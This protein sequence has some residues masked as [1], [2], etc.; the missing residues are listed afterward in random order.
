MNRIRY[1]ITWPVACT[2]PLRLEICVQ[3]DILEADVASIH[4][5]VLAVFE[6]ARTGAFQRDIQRTEPY[7]FQWKKLQAATRSPAYLLEI[8]F[9]DARFC[10]VLLNVLERFSA[11]VQATCKL[12]VS[13]ADLNAFAQK[14]T[15]PK[16]TFN[17]SADFYPPQVFNMW[18]KIDYDDAPTDPAK[19]R[20]LLL[21]FHAD[22]DES[23]IERYIEILDIW[24]KVLELNGYA[25]PVRSVQEAMVIYDGAELYTDRIIEANLPLFEASDEAWNALFNALHTQS[26]ELRELMGVWL[27]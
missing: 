16:P 25:P 7:R 15:F 13:P 18:F 20:R 6:L 1:D 11:E 14:I 27:S 19:Y 22:L 8:S 3:D 17:N 26:T 21:V 9:V 23:M 12:I 10:A 5:H 4:E 2:G 24:S